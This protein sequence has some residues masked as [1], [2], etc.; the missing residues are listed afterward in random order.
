M[1]TSAIVEPG[2]QSDSASEILLQ[3][4]VLP[5]DADFDT[6]PLY[7]EAG[8]ARPGLEGQADRPATAFDPSRQVHPDLVHGRRSLT[9]PAGQRFSFA[10][11]FNAF[12]AGY[13]RRW[14]R[15]ETVRLR[16]Q[17]KGEATVL[18]YRTNAR[19]NQQ[20]VVSTHAGTGQ[21]AEFDLPLKQFG[22]G[23]W[24]WF[25]I[26]ASD[27]DVTLEQADWVTYLDDYEP[28]NMSIGI[29]TFNRPDYCVDLLH[30]LSHE[31]ELLDHVDRL[32][33]I[34]QGTQLVKEQDGFD[35]AATDL[36]PKL[37]LIHQANLGGSGG[38]SRSMYEATYTENSRFVL[39][40]DDDVLVEPEGVLRALT[41]GNLCRTPTIVGGHMI[42][43]YVR[44]LL[45][46]YGETVNRFRFFWGP[47][48]HSQH[49]HDFAMNPLR[50]TRWLHRRIDVDYNGWWMCLIPTEVV[51]EIGMS[52]PIFIKWDDAE[53]GLRAQKAGIPTVS[54]PGAAVW[55]VP[56][57]DKD[58]TIDW[59]AYHHA[60]NR[61][62]VALLHSPY[63]RGGRIVYESLNMQ[64]KHGLSM[65]YTAAELRL[66]AIEDLLSGPDH[67]HRDL[68]T[69]LAEVR[70]FR[71][72]KDDAHVETDAR[73]YPAARRAKP[74]KRGKDP[75]DPSGYLGR[76]SAAAA[77]I[78]RQIQP[79]RSTSR[80]NPEIKIAAIDSRWSLLSQFDSAVVSTADGSGAFWYK[81]DRKHF[82]DLMKRSVAL[83]RELATRWD[84]LADTYKKAVPEVTGP[85][86]WVKTWGDSDGQ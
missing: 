18:V 63:D 26:V 79:V 85:D 34:D 60:R 38:F 86:A 9:V 46:A 49:G 5:R 54:L 33:V 81:R 36:G 48:P 35:Q 44:S 62:L 39:L 77:G 75:T 32:L 3:R 66:M 24:Y 16:V 47:A 27:E 7:V 59:Q 12:P 45:H 10:T 23:G 42:N 68:P 64:V 65:Q 57:T 56:W 13:W 50:A 2:H 84:E 69:K 17:L 53:Y 61:L 4:V 74:P 20:R 22:D 21:A 8:Q 14:T 25:D 29:T 67:L 52:L 72:G 28:G 73:A 58:D 11:Y 83:H 40:L 78:L 37:S 76:Y 70:K 55:H 30:A 1:T 15:V 6:I 71:Q 43:M 41:F 51:R 82:L 19:G 31:Q 80:V